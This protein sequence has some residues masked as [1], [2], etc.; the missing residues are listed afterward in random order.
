MEDENQ[1]DLEDELFPG[2][3]L[4]HLEADVMSDL[5]DDLRREFAEQEWSEEDGLRRVL[6]AGLAYLRAARIR[7]EASSGADPGARMEQVLHDWMEMHGR[8]AL[9]NYRG[10]QSIQA[11]KILSLKLKACRQERDALRDVLGA[12]RTPRAGD[13]TPNDDGS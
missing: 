9:L 4:V 12:S 11:A 7:A 6:G 3:R 8:M 2:S 1:P 13:D 5:W 10:Y